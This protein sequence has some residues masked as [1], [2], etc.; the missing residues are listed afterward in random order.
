MFGVSD[1]RELAACRRSDPDLF[2]PLGPA[3]VSREQ[4]IAAKA[5]CAGCRVTQP[6]LDYA[7]ARNEDFGIWGGLTEE[8]R[9]RLRKRRGER[10]RLAV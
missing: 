9:R 2:F 7:I 6:C 3:H 5:V 1:W 4:V 10:G 8:E